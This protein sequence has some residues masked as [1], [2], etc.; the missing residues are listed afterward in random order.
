M[1]AAGRRCGAACPD[2]VQHHAQL[3]L[4]HSIIRV[5]AKHVTLTHHLSKQIAKCVRDASHVD[6]NKKMLLHLHSHI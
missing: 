4:V 6:K 5:D 3:R 2:I 1:V